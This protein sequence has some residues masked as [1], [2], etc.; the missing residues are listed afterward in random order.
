MEATP[1]GF[2]I[3][4]TKEVDPATAVEPTNYRMASYT[5]LLHEPYGS[6][7]T[8]TEAV[9]IEIA[10]VEGDNRSVLLRCAN[11]R[12]GYVHELHLSGVRDQAGDPLLHDVAYYTLIERPASPPASPPPVA[13]KT[14]DASPLRSATRPDESRARVSRNASTI[15]FTSDSPITNGGTSLIT[16]EVRLRRLHEQVVVF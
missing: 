15:H 5:Y 4:F 14:I 3:T 16:A 9:P 7:E 13:L 8:N 2:R 11:L 1:D 6:P 12:S 10:Q